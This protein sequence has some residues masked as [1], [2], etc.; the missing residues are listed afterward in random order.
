MGGLRYYL[1]SGDKGRQVIRGCGGGNTPTDE[2]FGA[3][4]MEGFKLFDDGLGIL[5]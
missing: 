4:W 3:A 1:V 2:I 5:A